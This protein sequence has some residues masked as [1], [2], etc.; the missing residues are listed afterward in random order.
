MP[1]LLFPLVVGPCLAGAGDDA[2][3]KTAVLAVSDQMTRAARDLDA[4]RMFS[5]VLDSTEGPIAQNGTLLMTRA[6]ALERVRAGFQGLRSID[7]RWKRRSVTVLGPNAAVLA[8]DGETV[9]TTGD[10]ASFSVP[11]AQT[12]VFVRRGGVWRLTHGHY[13]TVPQ[14]GR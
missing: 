2:V 7:Y 1:L 10:G 11:F 3:I 6:E 13:S 9:V 12:S 5:F 14:R 4:E 8:G